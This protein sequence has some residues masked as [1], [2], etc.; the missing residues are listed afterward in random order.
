MREEAGLQ[1]M[2]ML[3]QLEAAPAPLALPQQ[4]TQRVHCSPPHCRTVD[5]FLEVGRAAGRALG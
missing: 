1:A 3:G 5:E 4:L 2:C